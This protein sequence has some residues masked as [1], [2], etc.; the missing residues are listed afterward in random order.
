MKAILALFSMKSAPSFW[1]SRSFDV[2]LVIACLSKLLVAADHLVGAANP[3][4][5][6]GLGNVAQQTVLEPGREPPQ[7]SIT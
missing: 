7:D 2:Q 1:R 5:G 3:G 4:A 6:V